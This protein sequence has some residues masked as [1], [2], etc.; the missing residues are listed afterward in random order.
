ML[1]RVG[2]TQV[3][4]RVHAVLSLPRLNFTANTF[5]WWKAL[6]PLGITPTAGTGAFWSQVNT[7]VMEGVLEENEY[8]LTLDY[9]SFV[10]KEDVEQLFAMAL[11]FQC[12]ALAPIQSK[13]EDGRPMFTLLDTLDN[14]PQ[15][16]FTEVPTEWFGHP[17][18]QVDAAH[19]GCTILSTAA[20]KRMKKPW[21]WS[22]PDDRGSWGDGHIDDDMW[23]WRQWKASGN[24]LFIT[25]RV[26]IGHGEYVVCY[27][28]R[29]FQA[30]VFQYATDFCN[31]NKKPE[32]A[33]R[34]G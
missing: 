30:P 8:I 21:F 22:K 13:R 26:V 27:P 15:N 5:G 17:V 16:G 31:T 33:W 23:F 6:V 2:D 25:P 18:Q 19:F 32:S 3:D 11:A 34:I 14:P 1:V 28:G 9:D 20:L 12:D 4:V 7:R 24:K 10:L 29:D